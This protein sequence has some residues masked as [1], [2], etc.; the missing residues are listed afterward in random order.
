MLKKPNRLVNFIF[1]LACEVSISFFGSIR[2]LRMDHRK[3]RFFFCIVVV[4]VLVNRSFLTSN[5]QTLLIVQ[6][7]RRTRV[8]VNS[9]HAEYDSAHCVDPG[10][11]VLSR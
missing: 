7:V 1:V 4:V 10:A 9:T 8:P 6:K 5:R 2:V 3:V 11:D